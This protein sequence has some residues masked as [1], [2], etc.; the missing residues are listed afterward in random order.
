[1]ALNAQNKT[2]NLSDQSSNQ[3]YT[4]SWV[5]RKV[6]NGA[7]HTWCKFTPSSST[8]FSSLFEDVVEYKIGFVCYG[9]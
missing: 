2:V 1:M 3:W 6:N 7:W 4:A 9:F 8:G 5:K